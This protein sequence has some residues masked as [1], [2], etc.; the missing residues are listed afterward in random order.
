MKW[1]FERMFS[2]M[3]LAYKKLNQN[4]EI[5]QICYFY[6]SIKT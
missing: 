6:A 4:S 5:L 1:H 2:Y 3:R